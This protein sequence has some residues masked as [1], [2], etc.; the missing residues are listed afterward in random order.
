MLIQLRF[1]RHGL[2]RQITANHALS[3]VFCEIKRLFISMSQPN[4]TQIN[5]PPKMGAGGANRIRR[6]LFPADG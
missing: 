3:R 5:P 2:S 6:L 4:S 1:S